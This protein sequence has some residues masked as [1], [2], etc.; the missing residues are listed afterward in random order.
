MFSKCNSSL[1]YYIYEICLPQIIR[2]QDKY[3]VDLYIVIYD[4]MTDGF[5]TN[6]TNKEKFQLLK[7]QF[8]VF[9]K[10]IKPD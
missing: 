6:K 1:Q 5:H 7:I 8:F 10:P 9:V 3:I 4:K 2:S